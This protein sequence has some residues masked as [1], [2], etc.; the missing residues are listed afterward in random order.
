LILTAPNSTIF[1]EV[2]NTIGFVTFSVDYR[3]YR[4]S[5]YREETMCY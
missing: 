1:S 3:C 5:I 2:F 4:K